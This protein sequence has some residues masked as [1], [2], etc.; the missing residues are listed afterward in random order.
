MKSMSLDSAMETNGAVRYTEATIN[1]P[2]EDP[3][4]TACT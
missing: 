1:E 4:L 2:W 3:S